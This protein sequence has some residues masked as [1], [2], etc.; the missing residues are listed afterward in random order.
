MIQVFYTTFALSVVYLVY[1]I[2]TNFVV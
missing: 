2:S 1:V